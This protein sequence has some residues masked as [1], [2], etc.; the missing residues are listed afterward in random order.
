MRV[1]LTEQAYA[2]LVGIGEWIERD[3][4]IRAS[5]FVDELFDACMQLGDMPKAFPLIAEKPRSGIRKRVY[6]DY[7]IFYL[8]E[9]SVKVLHVTH[10][11]RDYKRVLFPGA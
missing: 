10:G 1:H 5:T 11:A 6:G 7:L 9:E 8:I 3:S 4:P 2:D